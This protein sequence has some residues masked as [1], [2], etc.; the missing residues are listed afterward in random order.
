MAVDISDQIYRIILISSKCIVLYSILFFISLPHDNL[1]RM[2]FAKSGLY[3]QHAGRRTILVCQR[4]S[5]IKQSVYL[6]QSNDTQGMMLS[7]SW[8]L[9]AV[10]GSPILQLLHAF[11][12]SWCNFALCLTRRARWGDLPWI[13]LPPWPP[14]LPPY[15]LLPEDLIGLGYEEPYA[16]A[17]LVSNCWSRPSPLPGFTFRATLAF[18]RFVQ[19]LESSDLGSPCTLSGPQAKGRIIYSLSSERR[20]KQA[21]C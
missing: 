21:S 8:H 19:P 6:K 1:T 5:L 12:C 7:P 4:K 13:L 10:S 11:W 15:S 16:A 18:N 20:G 17:P 3:W 2:L 14:V 9:D